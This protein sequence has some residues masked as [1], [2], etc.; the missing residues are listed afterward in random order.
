MEDS[1]N[2]C[3]PWMYCDNGTCKCG[4]IPHSILRCACDDNWPGKVSVLDCYCP[5]YN[6]DEDQNEAG[7]CISNCAKRHVGGKDSVYIGLSILR[8]M[9]DPG[10]W[11]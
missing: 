2:S 6:K 8:R 3:P 7:N 5:T 4:D 10:R 1:G 11:I 9:H